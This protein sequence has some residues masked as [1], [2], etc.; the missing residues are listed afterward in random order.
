MTLS[1]WPRLTC[2]MRYGQMVESPTPGEIVYG[3]ITTIC[4]RLD[5]DA[6]GEVTPK[7][8]EALDDEQV[9]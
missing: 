4:V 9:S 5:R 1:W 2:P 8:W 6:S 7:T 3:P